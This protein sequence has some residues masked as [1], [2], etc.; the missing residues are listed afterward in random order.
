[1]YSVVSQDGS[2]RAPGGVRQQSRQWH[3]ARELGQ[4]RLG[5]FNRGFGA[6]HPVVASAGAQSL[7]V[8]FTDSAVVFTVAVAFMAAGA[9]AAATADRIAGRRPLD[10][11]VQPL[12]STG[13]RH[14]G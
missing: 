6:T 14:G 5:N 4:Q 2:H 11:V 3:Q 7:V 12:Y 8:A 9:T 1:V 13:E 10:T